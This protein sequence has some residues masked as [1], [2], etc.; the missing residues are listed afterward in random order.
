MATFSN[1]DPK[2][3]GTQ[4]A[5]P[6]FILSGQGEAFMWRRLQ[7]AM[8]L[9]PVCSSRERRVV[10]IKLIV[11][12]S[13]VGGWSPDDSSGVASLTARLWS[14]P[15]DNQL[16]TAATDSGNIQYAHGLAQARPRQRVGQGEM[17]HATFNQD[18]F[19]HF[20]GI[21]TQRCRVSIEQHL[22]GKK[23][24]VLLVLSA[25]CRIRLR[26]PSQLQSSPPT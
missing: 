2:K 7:P 14:E 25:L 26:G 4:I 24:K 23:K 5:T 1:G 10:T 12:G 3:R 8:R 9:L 13:E 20:D 21:W 16:P 6:D 18:N 19:I 15:A 22:K 11:E 17:Q